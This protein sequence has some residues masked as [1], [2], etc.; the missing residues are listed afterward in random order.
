MKHLN[1]VSIQA[2]MLPEKLSVDEQTIMF[3]D[4]FILK[5]Y[6]KYEKIGDRFQ[7]DSICANGYT[8]TFIS[9]TSLLLKIH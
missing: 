8:I 9:I 2:A 7:C 4:E 1:G 5:A 6:I 3:Y